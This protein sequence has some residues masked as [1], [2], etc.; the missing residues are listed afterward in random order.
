MIKLKV[1]ELDYEIKNTPE[2]DAMRCI[3]HWLFKAL[4]CIPLYW[5]RVTRCVN[6]KQ[7]E[8][9]MYQSGN[10]MTWIQFS[11]SSYGSLTDY[12]AARNTRFIIYSLS[13]RCVEDFS[14]YQG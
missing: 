4:N 9:D 5:G 12:F 1:R 7:E 2:Y 14:N 13:G 11:S 8:L 10:I 3:G 6:L